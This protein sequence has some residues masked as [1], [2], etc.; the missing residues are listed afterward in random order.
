MYKYL[1]MFLYYVYRV[2]NCGLWM[3]YNTVSI[4]YLLCSNQESI[5]SKST[6]I[7]WISYLS[8]E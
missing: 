3:V 8:V 6:S 4:L 7:P 2:D 1:Y 5:V